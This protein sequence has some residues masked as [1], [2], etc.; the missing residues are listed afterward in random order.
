MYDNSCVIPIIKSPK[1]YQAY[2]ISPCDSNRLAI[3]F[4]SASANTA[5]KMPALQKF[6][7]SCFFALFFIIVK[8]DFAN[9]L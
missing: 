4:D 9:Q 7:N 5:G 2:R 6:H 3:I 8:K 1:D